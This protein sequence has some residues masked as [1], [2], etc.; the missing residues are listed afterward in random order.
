MYS[1]SRKF[2]I[3]RGLLELLLVAAVVVWVVDITTEHGQPKPQNKDTWKQRDGFLTLSYG[4]LS[5]NAKGS[6]MSR[7]VFASHLKTLKDAGFETITTSDV[8]AF[9]SEGAPLPDKAVYIMFEGGR[10]DS[11]IYGQDGLEETGMRATMCL[12]TSQLSQWTRTFLTKSQIRSLGKS[13]FWDV[14]S[15]GHEVYL[16]PPATTE[17][18]SYFLSDFR[19]G[20]TGEPE[21]DTVAFMRRAEND[22]FT[23]V[24]ELEKLTGGKPQVY[25]FMPANSMDGSPLPEIMDTNR[26]LIEDNFAIA[27][28]REGPAFNY[29]SANPLELS[30]MRIPADYT[31][32]D[33]LSA[34]SRW[35]PQRQSYQYETSSGEHHWQIEKGNVEF[36]PAFMRLTSGDNGDAQVWLTGS[37][38]WRNLRF[39]S[40]IQRH[41]NAVV[42]VYLRCASRSSF[43]RVEFA[44][45]EMHVQERLPGEGLVTLM[46]L[47]LA[48]DTEIQFA[49]SLI[50]NRLT[51]LLNDRVVTVPPLPVAN[52]HAGRILLSATTGVDDGSSIELTGIAAKSTGESWGPPERSHS[53]NSDRT[54]VVVDISSG[55]TK[56]DAGSLLQQA[57]TGI[58]RYALF[59]AGELLKTT[60]LATDLLPGKLQ[61]KIWT[62]VVYRPG[63]ETDWTDVIDEFKKIRVAGLRTAL[64]VTMKEAEELAQLQEPVTADYLLVSAEELSPEVDR[65]LRRHYGVLLSSSGDGYFEEGKRQ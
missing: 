27:F 54:A 55:F 13:S 25:V 21:E 24:N 59:P 40:R 63:R 44:A 26:R 9:Y 19:R 8:V 12:N 3:I 46:V 60:M 43:V 36:L 22:Y 38:G 37:E 53:G 4:G 28:T 23:T 57:G 58:D 33:L 34:I 15:S 52:D 16:S 49:A 50:N 2:K 29:Q 32:H 56:E 20:I 11:A 64:L 61:G 35:F 7:H 39:S 30:R 51:I 48:N 1:S 41:E 14:C 47:P 17:K 45:D 62:G 10:R 65:E 31:A 5:R 18:R 42:G 6:N